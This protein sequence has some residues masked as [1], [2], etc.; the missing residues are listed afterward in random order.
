MNLRVLIVEDEIIISEMLREML[1]SEGVVNIHTAYNYSE[2]LQ[3]LATHTF[4]LAFLDVNIGEGK[5]GI[6]LGEYIRSRFKMCIVF[7]T[8]FSDAS[9]LQLIASLR[10][11]MYI[12]KPYRLG[13]IRAAVQIVRSKLTE[14]RSLDIKVG[15]ELVKV[16][17]QTIRYVKTDNIYLIIFTDSKRYLVR[18]TLENFLEEYKGVGL[19]K[20]HRSYAVAIERASKYNDGVIYIEEEEIPVSKSNRKEIQEL[21]KSRDDA[22]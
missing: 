14:E 3:M 12:S 13:D 9:T 19:V 20:V 1:E 16:P 4:D 21:F 10:P 15:G 17:L 6:D 8:S 18:S 7:T 11:E 5:T 2:A 22:N